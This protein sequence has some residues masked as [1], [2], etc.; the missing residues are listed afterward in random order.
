MVRRSR[1]GLDIRPRQVVVVLEY[2]E[3]RQLLIA[4]QGEVWA[5]R[6]GKPRTHKQA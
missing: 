5:C 4:R 3:I 6:A 1:V 2:L